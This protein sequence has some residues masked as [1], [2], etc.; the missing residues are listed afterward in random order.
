MGTDQRQA[1]VVGPQALEHA[2]EDAQA[3]RVEELDPLH[4]HEDAVGTGVD[5][6]VQAFA[7]PGR[8]VDVDLAADLQDRVI[9]HGARL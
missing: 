5:Q 4:V 7:E 3:G 8:G 2:D 6:L 1:A 9:R